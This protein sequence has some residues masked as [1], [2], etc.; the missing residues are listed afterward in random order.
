RKSPWTLPTGEISNGAFGEITSGAYTFFDSTRGVQVISQL[1]RLEAELSRR[2]VRIGLSATL[3]SDV[4]D[5][6]RRFLRPAGAEGVDVVVDKTPALQA[7]DYEIRTFVE[8]ERGVA[9]TALWQIARVVEEDVVKPMR[10]GER[11]PTHRKA[12]MFCNSRRLVESFT[13][14]IRASADDGADGFVYPH[15]GS[16]DAQL[17]RAAESA[18]RDSDKP[19][20][21]VS[22]STLELGIDIGAID[23]VVQVDP[24]PTVA[25]LRQR[26]GRSGRRHGAISRLLMMMR[27][28][29]TESN[30]HPLACMHFDL[31]Q[32]LAQISLVVDDAY[33]APQT[34]ALHLSTF[35]QQCLSMARSGVDFDD[36]KQILLREGP[37]LEEEEALYRRVFDYLATDPINRPLLPILYVPADQ[38]DCAERSYLTPQN[39]LSFVQKPQFGTSFKTATTYAV[40]LGG[41]TLGNLPVGHNL[42]PGDALVFAGQML[43]VRSVIEQPATLLVEPGD[44]GRPPPFAG[45]TVAPSGLVVRTMRALF[46]GDIAL[47]PTTLCAQTRALIDEARAVFKEQGLH[48]SQLLELEHDAGVALFPWVGQKAQSTLAILLRS[49]G[50]PAL[51]MHAALSIPNKTPTELRA[52]LDRIANGDHPDPEDLIRS[53]PSHQF[54]RYDYLLSAFARRQNYISARVDISGAKAAAE[55]I[56]A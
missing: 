55:A 7:T 24:G 17:R 42:K 36:V 39:G 35:V 1:A 34:G 28:T 4:G 41:L 30:R 25:S 8:K 46:A 38:E 31:F 23:L 44:Q 52:A 5:A 26:L 11:A 54:D 51:A 2:L 21:V 47:P 19:H 40:R 56:L 49:Q 33:E 12:L 16:L 3:S 45:S 53:L 32:A 15:H 6:A 50:L 27:A 43:R 48:R 18:L 22:T 14:G 10:S 20:L 37:F 9:Q 29:N 13:Q